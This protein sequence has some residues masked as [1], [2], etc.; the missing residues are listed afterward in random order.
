MRTILVPAVLLAVSFPAA[1]QT[2]F[3]SI[4]GTVTDA[5][6]VVPGAAIEVMHVASGYKYKANSNAAGHYT[7]GQLREGEYRL[8]A[9]AT[10]FREFLAPSILLG[11][12]DERRIDVHL[13]V[14]TVETRI[15]VSAGATLI[16][17]RQRGSATLK[18]RAS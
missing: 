16:E 17:R 15:E 7:L 9:T 3:G 14:G 11:A 13:Q 10:G 12:R 1:A 4:T 6:A 8:R 2:T 5:G 18:V